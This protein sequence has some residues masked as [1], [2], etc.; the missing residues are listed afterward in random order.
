MVVVDAVPAF[1]AEGGEEGR[2]TPCGVGGQLRTMSWPS[3]RR[4]EAE[5]RGLRSRTQ[6]SE[7]R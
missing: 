7:M 6:A 1:P 5:T 2:R 4:A 3:V